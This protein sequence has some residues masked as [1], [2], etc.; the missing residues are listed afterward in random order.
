M[1]IENATGETVILMTAK[2]SDDLTVHWW[3]PIAD[4]KTALNIFRTDKANAKQMQEI[5]AGSFT[6]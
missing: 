5:K 4:R 6:Y 1:R 2:T 3:Q